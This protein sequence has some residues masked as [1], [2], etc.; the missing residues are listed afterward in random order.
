MYPTSS[1]SCKRA[2]SRLAKSFNN[3]TYRGF[4]RSSTTYT[5]RQP[6]G[7]AV[8]NFH[9]LSRQSFSTT[10][11]LSVK[12]KMPPKKK[13]EEVKKVQL[14]R[15]GNNLKVGIFISRAYQGRKKNEMLMTILLRSVLSV[16]PTLVNHLSSTLCPRRTWAK[17]P[18]SLTPPCELF[19]PFTQPMPRVACII[20]STP[21]SNSPSATQRRP[22][23]PSQTTVSSGCAR[24]TSPNPRSPLSSPAST[25]QV[26]QPEH[27]RV[28]VSVT[29]SCPMSA[30]ST[31]SSKLSERLTMQRSFTLK[32]TLTR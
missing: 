11:T 6:A 10:S 3:T 2:L 31:V 13:T 19:I 29:P 17:L 16:S 4:S 5:T 27:P 9:S 28:Q 15:P 30:P 12:R 23:S 7:Q 32:A 26:S 25:L 22:V 1:S 24:H 18:T 14:G 20:P 21:H 8:V